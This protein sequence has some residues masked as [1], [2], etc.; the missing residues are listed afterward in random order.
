MILAF[1][2]VISSFLP[3]FDH[4]SH[5]LCW[6]W[7]H[8]PAVIMI[9]VAVS[10]IESA[11]NGLKLTIHDSKA[12]TDHVHLFAWF[13]ESSSVYDAVDFSRFV[14]PFFLQLFKFFS[15]SLHDNNI[16]TFAVCSIC[17]VPIS[18]SFAAVDYDSSVHETTSSVWI[19]FARD[20]NRVNDEKPAFQTTTT[21][22]QDHKAIIFFFSL[23]VCCE[24]H[25]SCS[26]FQSASE[27]YWSQRVI[28]QACVEKWKPSH[29]ADKL[30]KAQRGTSLQCWQT[31]PHMIRLYPTVALR[32]LP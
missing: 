3:P 22:W 17:R 30:S 18:F 5:A 23:Y 31:W 7:M 11:W 6:M 28:D 8:F 16:S 12:F 26:N 13:P 25:F 2:E 9:I 15:V 32:P 1:E 27:I 10:R 21:S 4:F 14:R 19:W 20:V 29:V 24:W